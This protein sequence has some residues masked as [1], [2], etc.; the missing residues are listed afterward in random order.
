M[1]FELDSLSWT[2]DLDHSFIDV[3]LDLSLPSPHQPG[4]GA[5]PLDFLFA[6]DEAAFPGFIN[7][8]HMA[9]THMHDIGV[10]PST[11]MMGA[12]L[13][14][15]PSADIRT[16]AVEDPTPERLRSQLSLLSEGSCGDELVFKNC[17]SAK[18]V[19]L[20]TLAIEFGLNYTHDAPSGEVSI[21]RA[22][23]TNAMSMSFTEEAPSIVLTSPFENISYPPQVELEADSLV[24]DSSSMA[25][26]SSDP[27]RQLT[28]KRRPSR[29]QRI[30]D[31]ITRHVSTWKSSMSKGGG[32]RRGPLTEDGR[33][34]MKVLEVAGGA[35]WRCKVLRRKVSKTCSFDIEGSD[36]FYQCDPG[37]PCRC[38]LQSTPMPHLGDDAPLWPVIGCR[39]GPLRDALP[40]LILCP[41]L[42]RDMKIE[43]TEMDDDYRPRRSL[44]VADRCLLSAESQRLADMKAVLE[45]AAYKLSIAD[46]T[47]K[48]SFTSFVETGRYRNEECLHKALVLEDEPVTYTEMIATIGWELAENH[49]VLSVLEMKSW[50]DFMNMLETACIYE[51]GFG[52]VCTELL[53]ITK[54]N[55]LTHGR[56]PW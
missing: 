47:T 5:V 41:A 42:L 17:D 24:D 12:H 43:S 45:G 37:T 48:K 49:T 34:D 44:D 32:G 29:S 26:S 1:D 28:I 35:C 7:H 4:F 36:R 9:D 46:K 50:D 27:S 8:D 20:H 53:T 30:S 31:S 6:E 38:C 54:F 16:H 23:T 2:D 21:T 18:A 3:D 13:D 39:R 52:Q 55:W 40:L 19:L 33:R 11:S 10:D 22:A 51:S 15:W 56:R 14:R 25:P